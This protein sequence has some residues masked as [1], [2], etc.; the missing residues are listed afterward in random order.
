M[1]QNQ[2][3]KMVLKNEHTF[4]FNPG[5]KSSPT[6][7]GQCPRFDNLLCMAGWPSDLCI[8]FD[9]YQR[10]LVIIKHKYYL[11]RLE[12]SLLSNPNSIERSLGNLIRIHKDSRNIQR[13]F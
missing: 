7:V 10:V 2:E 6:S 8:D 11:S 1:K 9:D 12:K 5:G 13:K 3:G 4:L